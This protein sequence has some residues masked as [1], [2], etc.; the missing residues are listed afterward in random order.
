MKSNYKFLLLILVL[1][2]VILFGCRQPAAKT[3]AQKALFGLHLHTSIDTNQLATGLNPGEYSQEFQGP[4][5]QWINITNANIYLTNVGLHSTTTGQWYTIPGSILLK[6]LENEEYSIDSVPVDTYDDIRFTV[7]LNSSLNSGAPSS[8]STTSGPDTVLSNNESALYAGTGN[9][10]YF[11]TLTGN[12]DT[13]A[14][15]NLNHPIPFTYQLAGDTFQVSPPSASSGNTF[16]IIP[17]V[18]GAQFVHIII[19]YGKLLQSFP[20]TAP[21]NIRTTTPTPMLDSIK[22]IFFYECST[23][24]GDC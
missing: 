10:Y 20:I 16:S 4:N 12:I 14:L 2:L 15:H 8:Y 17:G 24:N 11:V 21:V 7:G 23:P 22:T 5:G 3:I 13:S 1:M 9:G 18:P 19:D 6:R